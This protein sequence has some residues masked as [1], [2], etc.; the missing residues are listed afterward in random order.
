MT[1]IKPNKSQGQ[2]SWVGCTEDAYYKAPLSQK[3]LRKYQF[4]CLKHIRIYNQNW[5][6]YQGV[7]VSDAEKI[8]KSDVTWG[9]PSWPLGTSHSS[10][11]SHSTAK[12]FYSNF[13]DISGA[14]KDLLEGK[15]NEHCI[16]LK[17]K[18]AL[19][20][21]DLSLPFKK[22]QLKAR[23]KSLVKK[24]HPDRNNGDKLSEE[25]FKT[26]TEAYHTALSLYSRIL[27]S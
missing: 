27:I 26:V 16:S 24:H 19:K 2:C 13:K 5:N 22:N 17:E 3:Q 10:S 21:L 15:R 18:N 11:Y 14:Q 7:S 4:F 12:T 6:Y 25:K 9:R 20:T 23:Y 1:K 8:W